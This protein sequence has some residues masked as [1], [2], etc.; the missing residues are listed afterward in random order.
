M[1][2]DT[3]ALTSSL[4]TELSREYP[5]ASRDELDQVATA[6][7][8]KFADARIVTFLPILVQREAKQAMRL[9][10]A[11]GGSGGP[12]TAAPRWVPGPAAS[13]V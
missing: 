11:G 5:W 13:S 1:T 6:T 8:A 10:P 7:A 4:V 3:A 2:L 9:L 12:R